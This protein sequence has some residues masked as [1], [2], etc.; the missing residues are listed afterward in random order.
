MGALD[1]FGILHAPARLA[2]RLLLSP[3]Y[4]FHGVKPSLWWPEKYATERFGA[5][6]MRRPW[7]LFDIEELYRVELMIEHANDDE[8]LRFRDSHLDVTK[9]VAVVVSLLHH[10]LITY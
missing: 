1:I 4:L 6:Y 5:H 3:K 8:I 9:L 2:C 10:S 7:L